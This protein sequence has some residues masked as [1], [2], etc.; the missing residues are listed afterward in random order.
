MSLCII[1]IDADSTITSR[2]SFRFTDSDLVPIEL[3]FVLF[4]T[5]ALM[6]SAPTSLPGS[7]CSQSP[8]RVG[9]AGR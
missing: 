8:C 9:G 5:R 3:L 4:L 7:N 1:P 6:R 2:R